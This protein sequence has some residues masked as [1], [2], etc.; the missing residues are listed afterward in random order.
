MESKGN[1]MTQLLW[2]AGFVIVWFMLQAW[3]LPKLGVST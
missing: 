3:I 1:A 2:V